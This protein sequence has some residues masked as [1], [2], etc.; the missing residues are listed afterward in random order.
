MGK[1]DRLEHIPTP[2]PPFKKYWSHATSN[3]QVP[4]Q[5]LKWY[6]EV[7]QWARDRMIIYVK[8]EWPV[9][10]KVTR[11]AKAIAKEAGN[12][13]EYNYIDKL[14]VLPQ[15]WMELRDKY[16]AGDYHL[17]VNDS[18]NST[19]LTQVWIKEGWRDIQQ[20]PPAD[21]RIQKVENVDLN[22]PGNR[23]YVEYL[24]GRG[25]L[26]E[27]NQGGQGVA[28]ATAISA[29]IAGQSMAMADKLINRLMDAKDRDKGNNDT[30]ATVVKEVMEVMG[31]VT[32][33]ASDVMK[34]AY[35]QTANRTSPM[36][37]LKEV[38]AV[39]KELK[40]GPGDGQGAEA[41]TMMMAMMREMREASAANTKMMMEMQSKQI[42]RLERQ[43]E[44]Q[45]EVKTAPVAGADGTGAVP[46]S[47]VSSLVTGVDQIVSVVQKLGFSKAGVTDSGGGGWRD[48][49]PEILQSAQGI[50]GNAAQVWITKM[51]VDEREAARRMALAAGQPIMMP[52]AG[53]APVT[54]M[55][56]VVPAP[57]PVPQGSSQ[58]LQG[59]PQPAP[60]SDEDDYVRFM[61]EIKRP[62]MNHV[63]RN[64]GGAAFGQWIVD[65]YDEATYEQIRVQG[66]EEFVRGVM[67]YEPLALELRG[68]EGLLDMFADEFMRMA[69]I[70][71]ED[72]VEE[73]RGEGGDGE[74]EEG[75]EVTA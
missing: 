73:E 12:P 47:Q 4:N 74:E 35:E 7:P 2:S 1:A 46:V 19:T 59:S 30:T 51:Q 10:V 9:L 40:G 11:E 63:N 21:Q 33:K 50:I 13:V 62:L 29:G 16:G 15:D 71:A 28:E 32:E 52:G 55:P 39:F 36:D 61:S 17:S 44:R 5:L 53:M 72:A 67:G 38:A 3:S 34:S 54:Q 45:A 31:S 60:A 6:K 42:E 68:K 18:T 8:R 75:E 20:F 49:L 27:Q 64:L 43:L 58:N 24:R 57:V 48:A 69:E 37:S 23:S 56:P 65:S 25:K 41:T 14:D 26:P 70:M 22:D 66:K